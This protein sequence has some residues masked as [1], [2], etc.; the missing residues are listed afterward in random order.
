MSRRDAEQLVC[1]TCGRE[2]AASERFCADC[3]VP[4]AYAAAL[5][6]ATTQ[7]VSEL[8]RE[9]RKVKAAYTGG[10]LVRVTGARTQAEAELIQALLLNAGVPSMLR[11]A[12]GI[13]AGYMPGPYD[14][15]VPEAGLRAA[16][17]VLPV[18]E[19]GAER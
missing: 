6:G 7:P 5:E 18:S 2:Y 9:A 16:R 17:E 15:M 19:R 8:R 14:V 1:P 13:S 11:S 10:E 3:G 4:L 12:S